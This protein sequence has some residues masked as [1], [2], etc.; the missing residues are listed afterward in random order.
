MDLNQVGPPP[1]AG[2]RPGIAVVPG[3]TVSPL[4]R[5]KQ[6]TRGVR[7]AARRRDYPAFAASPLCGSGS[8]CQARL[9]PA[10]LTLKKWYLLVLTRPIEITEQMVAGL[11]LKVPPPDLSRRFD[12]ERSSHTLVQRN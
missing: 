1:C 3:R 7:A 4:R 8:P 2:G 6:R 9:L 12:P 10:T 5:G 11:K